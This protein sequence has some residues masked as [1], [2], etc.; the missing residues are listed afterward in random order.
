MSRSTSERT[1][2][3]ANSGI[4][5]A[6]ALMA[7]LA[8]T[9][10]SGT[11][12]LMSAS[13]EASSSGSRVSVER[14]RPVPNPGR[15]WSSSGAGEHQDEDGRIPGPIDQVVHEVE[16]PGVAV[17]GVLDEEH[18]RLR[19][20][21]PLEEQPPSGEKLLTSQVAVGVAGQR[22]PQKSTQAWTDV[23]P[24][25]RV[26]H[27]R[28]QTV[29]E[30]GGG[31]LQRVL[32]GDAQALADDLGQSPERHPFPVGEA[33]SP[34]PVDR[35]DQSVDVL[36]ELPPEPG[37][38]HPG[39]TGHHHQAGG[40]SL[41]AGVEQFLD[42]PQLSVASH[43]RRFEAVHALGPAHSRQHAVAVHRRRGSAL[44]FSSCSPTS[45]KPMA[46][47]ARR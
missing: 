12:A 44:P 19:V 29:D 33:A 20:G 11:R 10:M 41:R 40:P 15:D 42:R 3:T 39:R 23:V 18:H 7:A 17:L 4:P 26:G 13:M 30:L 31:D 16:E 28:L 9:G 27:E 5:S 2:S 21:Q 24:F 43:E 45:A 35:V 14:L 34:V 32:F 1:V 6:W 25:G 37:L 8:S 22:D 46:A 47:P 38:A 36:L